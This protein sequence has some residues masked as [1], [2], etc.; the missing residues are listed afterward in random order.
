M[1]ATVDIVYLTEAPG[2]TNTWPL[3]RTVHCRPKPADVARCVDELLTTS[4]PAA[5]LFWDPQLGTPN[6][7]LVTELLA[8]PEQAWHAGLCLGTGGLPRMLDPVV[9]TWMHNCD[10]PTGVEATSWRLSLS[11][12]LIRASV[13]EVVGN[14]HPEFNGIT[15]A[16]LELGHRFIRRGVQIR[17]VP[18]LLP[19]KT[20]SVRVEQIE[21]EDEIRF[22]YYRYGPKWVGW[23]SARMVLTGEANAMRTRL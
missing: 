9:A 21:L 8:Q 6:P 12:C 20:T 10:P 17:H 14:V 5:I 7:E 22:I 4:R 11:A 15:C 3:G 19:A 13:F 18:R 23:A 2:A 16:G 1:N